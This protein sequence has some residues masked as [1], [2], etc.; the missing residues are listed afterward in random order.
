MLSS[1]PKLLRSASRVA[2]DGWCMM[3]LLMVSTGEWVDT[4]ELRLLEL[5]RIWE[6]AEEGYRKDVL[7]LARGTR[8]VMDLK[9]EVCMLGNVRRGLDQADLSNPRCDLQRPASFKEEFRY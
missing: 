2:M 4:T 8:A 1:E 5:P 9:R 3:M 6:E 7:S